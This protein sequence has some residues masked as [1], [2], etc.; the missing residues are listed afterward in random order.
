MMV[1]LERPKLVIKSGFGWICLR[2]KTLLDSAMN[3]KSPTKLDFGGAFF[4]FFTKLV[5]L[6]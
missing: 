4:T 3:V 5:Q 1:L 6:F 2:A